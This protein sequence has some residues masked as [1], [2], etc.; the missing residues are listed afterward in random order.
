MLKDISA[1]RRIQEAYAEI[2]E[3]KMT[4]KIM[5]LAKAAHLAGVSNS[6]LDT[7]V[8][9]AHM[10]S[11]KPLWEDK[12]FAA[13]APASEEEVLRVAATRKTTVEAAKKA[14]EVSARVMRSVVAVEEESEAEA[15]ARKESAKKAN[16]ERGV[17]ES[18]RI[19]NVRTQAFANLEIAELSKVIEHIEVNT[20][21]CVSILKT[22]YENLYRE[23]ASSAECLAAKEALAAMS[24]KFR[25]TSAAGIAQR[26]AAEKKRVSDESLAKNA[27]LAEIQK[28]REL[29]LSCSKSKN[30]KEVRDLVSSM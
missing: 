1:F 26:D 2:P 3:T 22:E 28:L 29:L 19:A 5:A 8:K 15:T 6:H 14:S 11:M 18:K 16:A 4:K 25:I 10:F 12:D 30:M 17:L 7:S 23:N 21:L 24:S 20:Q 27:Y 13:I 9:S